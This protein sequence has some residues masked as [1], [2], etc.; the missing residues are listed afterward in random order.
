MKLTFIGANGSMGLRH[1]Q[2]YDCRLYSSQRFIWVKWMDDD[3]E[4]KQCPYSSIRKMLENW[5]E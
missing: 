2:T 4:L 5:K 1:G 3:G